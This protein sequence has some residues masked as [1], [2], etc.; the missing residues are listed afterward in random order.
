VHRTFQARD[1]APQAINGGIGTI[2]RRLDCRGTQLESITCVNIESAILPAI[3]MHA[4]VQL[5]ESDETGQQFVAEIIKVFLA[6]LS[7]RLK[8][9]GLQMSRGDRV[10]IAATAHAIKGSCG[11]FGAVRLME[12]S[13]EVEALAKRQQSDGLQ[14]AIDS[15]VAEAERV[16]TALETFRA[17]HAPS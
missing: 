13:L 6:D 12:L 2:S 14:T 17:D 4:I 3:D 11:H 7:E 1:S 9:L 5:A 16:R 10:G 8:T 15:M